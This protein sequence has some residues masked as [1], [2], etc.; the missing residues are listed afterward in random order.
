MWQKPFD[1]R[2][3][4]MRC[5]A[6]C[7]SVIRRKKKPHPEEWGKPEENE[8]FHVFLICVNLRL[9][10][11]SG[12]WYWGNLWIMSTVYYRFD[13]MTSRSV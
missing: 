8:V 3:K 9:P 12:R 4:N 2:N 10:R 5:A 6:Y 1:Y 11:S 13:P 7:Q